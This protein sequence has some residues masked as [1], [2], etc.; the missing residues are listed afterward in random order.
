MDKDECVEEKESFVK[1][2]FLAAGRYLERWKNV[3]VLL[4]LM[5]LMGG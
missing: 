4:E 3:C 1:D 5:R 2:K